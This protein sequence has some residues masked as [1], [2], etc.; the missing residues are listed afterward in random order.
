MRLNLPVSSSEFT[1]PDGMVVVS[2]TDLKGVI[3]YCNEAFVEASGRTRE[4][5][6]GSP[7]NIVR[8]PDMPPEAFADLWKT[9]KANKPWQ[10]IVKNRRKDG[11]FYWAVSNVTPLLEDGATIGYVAFRYKAT[12]AQ[13][14]DASTAYQEI[15][16]GAPELRIEEGNIIRA[17][18]R[19]LHWLGAASIK[20]RLLAFMTVLLGTL[21]MIGIFNLYEIS[22]ANSRAVNGLAVASVQA[23]ALDTAR[24]S[25][26]ILRK[27]LHSWTDILL[28]SHDAASMAQS[29]KDF[30]QQGIE[31]EKKLVGQLKPIMQQM[32][33]PTDS[34]D[35]LV[36]SHMQLVNSYHLALKS[37]DLHKP[38]TSL[39]VAEIVEAGGDDLKVIAQ[40]DKIIATIREAQLGGL[41]QLNDTLEKSYQSQN[42]RSIEILTAVALGGFFL[43]LWFIAGILKPVRR[44]GSHLDRVVQLQQQFL[45]KILAL[46]ENHDRMDE[47][48][49]IGSYIMGHITNA[50]DTLDP[51]VRYFVKPAEHL[52]GDMLLASRTPAGVL[53]ILLA[54][55]VGHGLTAAISVLPLSRIFYAMSEKGFHI[56]H[57]AEELNHQINSL[58]PADRFVAATLVA[59]DVRER[60]IEVWNGGNPAPLLV[61]KNG[62]VLRRWESNNLPIGIL[63]KQDFTA[64]PEKFQYNEECQLCMF[65]D[66][67]SEAKSPLG[68]SFGKDRI[69]ELLLHRAPEDRFDVLVAELESHLAGGLAHDDVT[70]AMINVPTYLAETA[71]ISHVHAHVPQKGDNDWK[72]LINLGA[73]ELKYLDVVPLL[74]GIVEKICIDNECAAPLFVILSELF[75][76]ALDHGILQIDSRIKQGNDGFDKYL[77]LREE[78]L[79]K[80]GCGEIEIEIEK[81]SVEEKQGVKIRVADSG[82][83][84]DYRAIQAVVKEQSGRDQHGRGIALLSSLVY[85]LEYIGNGNEVF[86]YYIF[87]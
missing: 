37:F 30:D 64:E 53:H 81:V 84:F 87:A 59:I 74:T 7:H 25:E 8:H 9:I 70:L 42:N 73:A 68:S 86:A 35:A 80:L 31:F 33:M 47:E 58:M 61:N 29:I 34:V 77:Q 32:G 52:S 12:Q 60:V 62:E 22:K 85:K 6:I 46:E 57:I 48:Q 63:A 83:G 55:A 56:A 76:N 39:I 75:N 78:R 54:D 71:P 69:T 23:Y 4:E 36:A 13:I 2:K 11:G 27:Q 26:S 72:I 19:L 15:R 82:N 79:S 43:S 3:T 28:D 50:R 14:D 51:L 38:E 21:I 24:I 49:R 41:G 17:K 44:T 1:L 20:T 66:G 16:R 10:G 65:S 45:G 67:L 18:N 5:I 40:I